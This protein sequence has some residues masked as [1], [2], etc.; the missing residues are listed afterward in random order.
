MNLAN[1]VD[2]RNVYLPYCNKC[3]VTLLIADGLNYLSKI[4]QKMLKSLG[5][6]Q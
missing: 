2:T 6:L 3:K 4:Y 1:D 5:L